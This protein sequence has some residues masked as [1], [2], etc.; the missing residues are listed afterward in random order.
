MKLDRKP[1]SPPSVKPMFMTS[2]GK[3]SVFSIS[4]SAREDDAE[5]IASLM[6]EYGSPLMIVD[7]EALRKN[8][9]SFRGLFTASGIRTSIGYSIKTNYLPALVSVLKDE[10][11]EAEVVSGM[12]YSLARALGYPGDRIIFNGPFKTRD[13]LER[14][15]SEG[16]LINIDGFQEIDTIDALAKEMGTIARIGIRV[17]FKSGPASWSKFGFSHESGDTTLAL[18]RIAQKTS[19]SL[20]A[21][22]NHSGTFNVEPKVY[23]DAAS[24]LIETVRRAQA[25]GLAPTKLDFGGGFPSMNKLKPG[26]DVPGGSGN[27]GENLKDF[28]EALLNRVGRSKSLFGEA[29]PEVILE[30][31]RAIVDTAVR[32]ACTV[33]ATKN[34]P[35]QGRAMIIDAGVNV[36]PTAYWYDHDLN[37]TK[38]EDAS[39]Q[40]GL[41]TVTVYGPLCMQIDVVRE[42]A[43]LPPLSTGDH[44][45]VGNVGAYCLSQSMQFIQPRPAI[46]IQTENGFELVR[47][48]ETWRDIFALDT[49]PDHVRDP[50]ASL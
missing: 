31:G 4:S 27:I 33:V 34:I 10:G 7:E 17:N 30:P 44:L 20:E 2:M 19:I 35:G 49:I 13:E 21:V 9:R 3:H 18:K 14:A 15:I 36:L 38:G 50:D 46:V 43:L 41:E 16:A 47:R 23:R 37:P 39:V 48:R 5:E 45:I 29:G 11:A 12:E 42:K 22:H 6:A 26:F 32:M 28:S 8:Y 1:Y 40:V 25:L 24:V